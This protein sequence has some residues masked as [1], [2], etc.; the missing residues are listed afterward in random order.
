M[1]MCANV[2]EV[3][4]LREQLGMFWLGEDLMTGMSDKFGKIVVGI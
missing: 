2:D 3:L 4:L 1:I